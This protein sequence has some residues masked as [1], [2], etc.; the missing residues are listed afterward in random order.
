MN[1]NINQAINFTEILEVIK[2]KWL[3]VVLV[4]LIAAISTG[5]LS[6]Y[7]LEPKYEASSKV[8]VGKEENNEEGY[9]SSDIQMYQKLLKTYSEAIQTIDLIERA[10]DGSTY[11]LSV[12]QVLEN[13]TVLPV[14][15]TQILEVKYEG[16][17]PL[18][19]EDTLNR[20]IS[21]FISISKELVPNGSVTI[22][23][24]VRLPKEPVSPNTKVNVVIAIV[25]GIMASIGVI[26]IME[27]IDNTYKTKSQV[28][29]ELNV[30]VIGV[31]PE[32][33]LI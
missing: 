1:G 30:P 23:Q 29:K 28:E 25:L 32:E 7:V 17:N 8:F 33:K 16:K 27:Y 24:K 14:N 20:I 3:F 31:I 22:I 2:R 9:N 15:D 19:I 6:I 11:N 13:I 12:D 26:M 10:I 4:T 21:E 5:V 18:E